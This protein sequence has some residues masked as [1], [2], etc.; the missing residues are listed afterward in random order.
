MKGGSF[1][2]RLRIRSVERPKSVN[3][4]NSWAS[5]VCGKRAVQM[6]MSQMTYSICSRLSLSRG[7]WFGDIEFDIDVWFDN[8]LR[9]FTTKKV[10]FVL[11]RI[12]NF[13]TI[14]IKKIDCMLY[15]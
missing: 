7:I 12:F 11:I 3:M 6:E 2:S 4:L 13:I 1:R 5:L 8:F 10:D 14:E 15:F 9:I